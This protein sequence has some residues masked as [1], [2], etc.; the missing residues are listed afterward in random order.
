[1]TST[2][3]ATLAGLAAL[4]LAAPSDAATLDVVN[5]GGKLVC[6][7]NTGLAGFSLAD[8]QGV[9]RGLDVD[10]CRAIAAAVLGDPAKV[11]FVALTAAAR[12][13]AL[14]TGEIDVLLRNST[15]TF[16]RDV[17][18]GPN[19]L[20]ANF[21]DGQGFSVRRDSGVTAVSGLNGATVCMAQGT[22]HEANALEWFTAR[23]MKFQPVVLESQD[24]MYK[25]FSPA[26]ATR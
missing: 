13:T 23:G 22:T 20:P 6:G 2:A 8:S 7:V 10:Y 9:W 21:Y 24:T 17:S 12:F 3:L 15:E 4:L 11:R 5:S 16:L 14:Q 18:I 26:A 19:A 25:A 1:M